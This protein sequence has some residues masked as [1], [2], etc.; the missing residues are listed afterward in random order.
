MRASH[1]SHEQAEHRSLL[2]GAAHVHVRQ[3]LL[4]VRRKLLDLQLIVDGD[5]RCATLRGAT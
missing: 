5:R 3:Q 1:L 2:H 4:R